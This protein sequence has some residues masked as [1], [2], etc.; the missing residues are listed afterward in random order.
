MKSANKH[1]AHKIFKTSL[2]L[3]G[4]NSFLEIIVGILLFLIKPELTESLIN[5]SKD[6]LESFLV[7][8]PL[9]LSAETRI[10]WAVYLLSHGIIKLGLIIGLWKKK[11]WTYIVAETVFALFAI[12]QV[13]RF[14]FTHSVYLILLTILDVIIITLTWL[15]YK[16]LKKR[17]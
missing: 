17:I 16:Q 1:L 11:L 14:V 4:A 8:L 9:G 3:K 10:F 6:F 13:Y 5:G 12:Y 15:E 2:F 7:D